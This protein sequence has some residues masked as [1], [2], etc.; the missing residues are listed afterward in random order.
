M[1]RD[2][3]RASTRLLRLLK[4]AF[5]HLVHMKNIYRIEFDTVFE[6]SDTAVGLSRYMNEVCMYETNNC[7]GSFCQIL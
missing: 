1:K 2:A 3:P 6:V 5:R 4:G 7:F